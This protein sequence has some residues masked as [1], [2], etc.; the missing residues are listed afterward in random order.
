[1]RIPLSNFTAS[2]AC[3][4]TSAVRSTAVFS[5]KKAYGIKM[6]S[7]SSHG[8]TGFLEFSMKAKLYHDCLGPLQGKYV[9]RCYGYFEGVVHFTR[10][11]GVDAGCLILEYC[12]ERLTSESPLIHEDSIR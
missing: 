1:M 12:G 2:G 9:P 5:D 8:A 11:R 10:R 6:L 7:A 3:N 4:A